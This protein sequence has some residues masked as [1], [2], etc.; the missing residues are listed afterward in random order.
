MIRQVSF[1][2]TSCG[3]IKNRDHLSI[4]FTQLRINAKLSHFKIRVQQVIHCTRRNNCL[5]L[6]NLMAMRARN[7]S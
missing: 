7:I 4:F 2:K 1:N 3:L 6:E 5:S